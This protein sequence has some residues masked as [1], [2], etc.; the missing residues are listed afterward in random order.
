VI[1][2]LRRRAS[3]RLVVDGDLVLDSAA[4]VCWPP[5]R[6]RIGYVPQD[7][8]LFPHL[9][10]RANVRFALGKAV[11]NAERRFDEVVAMLEIGT[12]LDRF[13]ATL[14]GGER[15]RVA[16]ARALA[17]DP[18]LLLLDEPLA[19]LDRALRERILPYLLRIRDTERIPI[20]HVTHHVGEALVLAREVMVLGD[21]RLVA[22]GPATSI[23]KEGRVT[24]LD[25]EAVLDNVMKGTIT[26]KDAEGGIATLELEANGLRL[27]VPAAADL[28]AGSQATYALPTEELM[29][30]LDR[31]DRISARNLFAAAITGIE[32]LAGDTLVRLE[33]GNIEW[34]ARLTPAATRE[35]GLTVG[36]RVWV[37][38]KTHAFRRL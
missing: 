16:L 38:I 4:G 26:R 22:H 27:A 3:G 14:S 33:A 11:E 2:G 28:D 35:L 10:V 18:R 36:M 30:A 15:Q 34:R 6:R 5:E 1:A 23:L 12:L 32:P 24:E 8:C 25:P 7:S 9:D 31:I 13:P 37:A 19:A 17:S 29:I 20:V 21:G